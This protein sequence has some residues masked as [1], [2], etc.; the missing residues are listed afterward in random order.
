M[1][2]P[3]QKLRVRK[4]GISRPTPSNLQ[5]VAEQ[6]RT[7][8]LELHGVVGPEALRAVRLQ[9]LLQAG[10]AT[11]SPDGTLVAAEVNTVAVSGDKTFRH[12]QG[13]ASDTWT[14]VHGLEKFPAVFVV[15]SAG[16]MVDGAVEYVDQNTAVLTFSA[17]FSGE[18]F[19]N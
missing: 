9:E 10:I 1:K 17:P 5:E 11:L 7:V 16:T 4:T 8:V 3:D 14:V 18:A 13:T 15:D 6:T 2:Y 19:F 12:V